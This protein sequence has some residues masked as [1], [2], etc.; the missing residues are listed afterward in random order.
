MKWDGKE[1]LFDSNING[2]VPFSGALFLV[3]NSFKTFL[4]RIRVLWSSHWKQATSPL[5]VLADVCTRLC[6]QVVS[7]FLGISNG[8]SRSFHSQSHAEQ[9]GLAICFGNVTVLYA[10][11]HTYEAGAYGRRLLRSH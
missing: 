9:C 8:N 10:I 11:A 4:S 7:M 3:A 2:V 1:R 5:A 6:F